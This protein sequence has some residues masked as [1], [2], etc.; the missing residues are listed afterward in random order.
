MK[1]DF[2]KE[3]NAVYFRLTD[4]VIVE[5]E[6]VAPGIV[7]D[8]D[9]DNT[10]AGI[11]ILNLSHKTPEQIKQIDFPFTPEDREILKSFLNLFAAV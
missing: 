10:V 9:E 3:V 7:Y 4:A 6:E 2:D 11:E 5:S 8:F 1:I